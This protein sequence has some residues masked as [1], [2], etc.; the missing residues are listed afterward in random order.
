[1][2]DSQEDRGLKQF[3]DEYWLSNEY[4]FAS[5]YG[6]VL[7]RREDKLVLISSS[8]GV[9][10]SMPYS[11]E[12]NTLIAASRRSSDWEI[13]TLNEGKLKLTK[14]HQGEDNLVVFEHPE[15]DARTAKWSPCGRFG[16][17][18]DSTLSVW[19]TDTGKL[20]WRQTAK[21]DIDGEII[22]SPL[23]TVIDWSQDGSS[24]VTSAEYMISC[25]IVVWEA[26]SG[27]IKT[28]V[29]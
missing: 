29:C 5:K 26:K 7:I 8:G 24:I 17:S 27:T 2:T 20:H 10:C 25:S 28:I 22:Y 12:G 16:H 9:I 4:S 23:L 14:F 3:S 21:F 6:E 13:L 11:G 18:N 1:M 15:L 19:H